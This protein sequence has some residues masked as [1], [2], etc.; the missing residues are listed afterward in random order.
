MLTLLFLDLPYSL[1][2]HSGIHGFRLHKKA[3]EDGETGLGQFAHDL[4]AQNVFF[5]PSSSFCAFFLRPIPSFRSM[6]HCPFIQNSLFREP[7]IPRSKQWFYLTQNPLN[8]N[9]GSDNSIRVLAFIELHRHFAQLTKIIVD[10][11]KRAFLDV[12]KTRLE[13]IRLVD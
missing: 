6:P 3:K 5:V 13:L 4:L 1:F 11:F 9:F 12:L 10:V 7:S 2:G 8:L